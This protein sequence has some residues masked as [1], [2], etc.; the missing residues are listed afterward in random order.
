MQ[1]KPLTYAMLIEHQ[2]QLVSLGE[3]NPQTAANRA[4][5]L[6]LFLRANA[7]ALEDVVGSEMRSAFPEALERLVDYLTRQGTSNRNIK[8]TRSAVRPWREAVVE[9]DTVRAMAGEKLPPFNDAFRSLVAGVPIK[10]IAR[11]A[12][13]P[14]AML[15]GWLKGKQPRGSN[16]KYIR[17]IESFFGAPRDSLVILAGITGNIKEK[18]RV[19]TASRIEYR[20]QLGARTRQPYWL[21]ATKDS[22]LRAQWANL[23]RYKTAP[24]PSL[25]RSPSGQWTFAPL[26]F[27]KKSESSWWAFLGDV[28]VPSARVN[29]AK[30]AAYLGWLA[31][32][33]DSKGAGLPSQD[34]QTLAWL[35]VSEYIEPFLEWMKER[36]GNKRTGFA[37][38]FLAMVAWMVRPGDGFL[39]QQPE[40]QKTLPARFWAEDWGRICE[41]QH[42]YCRRLSQALRPER[43]VGRDPF[44]PIQHIL[45]LPQPMEALADMVQ[46]MRQDRPVG[47]AASEVIWARDMLLIKLL[48]SNPLRRRNLATLTW[49]PDNTGSLYQRGDGSWWIRVPGRHFK[50]RR[51]QTNRKRDYDAPV[52]P[53]AW[54]DIERYLFRHRAQLL[55]SPSDLVFITRPQ[56]D[57]EHQH[58]PWV[59]LNSRVE[60]LTRKYLWRCNG[61]GAHAFRHLVA[62]SILKANGGDTMTAALVLNDR[63]DTVANYYVGLR[64]GDG[65]YRM[66]E[67]LG[68]TFDRM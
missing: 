58:R 31:L 53:S 55:R 60:H 68:K 21:R 59:D 35:A 4:T 25:N 32:D 51:A 27:G 67:L 5:A 3:V 66:A 41:R 33:R 28:E 13:V 52:H 50:N 43:E 11:L 56:G 26:A 42:T 49:K 36:S 29:W 57:A 37:I 54:T 23:L 14:S 16:A 22:P 47:C 39:A 7:V 1:D 18:P 8:N 62:T 9:D 12:S 63:E 45:D 64:S 19:G 40:Y 2:A 6:R 65:S 38:E 44:A 48:I 30:I 15:F 61:I 34:V 10:R 46:R 20:E 24:V 17:R